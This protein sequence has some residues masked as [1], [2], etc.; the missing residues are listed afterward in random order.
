MIHG[1]ESGMQFQQRWLRRQK[2]GRLMDSAMGFGKH[3]QQESA[4]VSGRAA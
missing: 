4:E 2:A 1:D 3:G